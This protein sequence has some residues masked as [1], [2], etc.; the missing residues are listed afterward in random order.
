MKFTYPAVIGKEENAY[1]QLR[2]NLCIGDSI[3]I[4]YDMKKRVE[5]LKSY[6]LLFYLL[7]VKKLSSSAL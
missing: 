2:K 4:S 6:T 5:S 7:S 3:G 1:Q